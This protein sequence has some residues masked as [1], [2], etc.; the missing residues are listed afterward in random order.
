MF[1]AFSVFVKF[2]ID[3][4]KS[5]WNWI[6][7]A[8]YADN[9][10]SWWSNINI[11][12]VHCI[13]SPFPSVLGPFTLFQEGFSEEPCVCTRF[14]VWLIFIAEEA[15][16]APLQWRAY[17]INMRLLLFMH[18][19]HWQSATCWHCRHLRES[20]KNIGAWLDVRLQIPVLHNMQ[21]NAYWHVGIKWYI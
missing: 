20:L 5:H 1:R 21:C 4:K 13:F 9:Y 11:W 2:Q 17:Y 14:L 18:R 3:P 16:L 8:K 15:E 6:Y 7:L 12:S 10:E 19:F